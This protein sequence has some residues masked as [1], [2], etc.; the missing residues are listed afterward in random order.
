MAQ[1]EKKVVIYYYLARESDAQKLSELNRLFIL[2]N[3]G[4]SGQAIQV[5]QESEEDTSSSTKTARV[6]RISPVR[7]P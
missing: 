7:F 5:S 2:L 1:V 4:C 6:R 3:P